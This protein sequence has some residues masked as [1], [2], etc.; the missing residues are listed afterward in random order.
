M[1]VRS[2]DFKICLAGKFRYRWKF[3]YRMAVDFEPTVLTG[4]IGSILVGLQNQCRVDLLPDNLA[5]F[6][7]RNKRFARLLDLDTRCTQTNGHFQ[8]SSR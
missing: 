6:I 7:G 2:A 3:T 4:D 5:Q 1:Q 8:I